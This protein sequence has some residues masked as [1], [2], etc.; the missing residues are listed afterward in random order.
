M[1]SRNIKDIK[2]ELKELLSGN[3]SSEKRKEYLN[4]ESVHR[5]MKTQWGNSG[6]EPSHSVVKRRIWNR[7]EA[8]CFD[9]SRNHFLR[10]YWMGIAAS[11]VILL[12]VA[13]VWL[14][15][16]YNAESFVEVVAQQSKLCILPDSTKVWMQ[17]GSKIRY[18]NRF[19]ENREVWLSGNSL[20]EVRHKTDNQSFKVYI[21]H[22]DIEVKGTCFLVKQGNK[23]NTEVTLLSGRI[24]LN[25]D[26]SHRKIVMHPSEKVQFNPS[27]GRGELAQTPGVDFNDG[28]Y[29]F[30]DVPLSR[31]V[32]FINQL[33]D[34]TVKLGEGVP[35]D[36][37]FSGSIGMNETVDDLADN[38]CFTMDLRKTEQN[39]T[40]IIK[41]RK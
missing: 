29:R 6:E 31:L 37:Q 1:K 18:S 34:T 10:K 20:F 21:N 19:S 2:N 8:E 39:N 11:I 27:T 35:A 32:E 13:G 26:K 36:E 23:L 9:T 15:P 12:A 25:L 7:V 33:S 24:E 5:K 3:L 40:I 14:V 16:M 4:S 28:R 30:T 41:L 17:R 22:A 38:I